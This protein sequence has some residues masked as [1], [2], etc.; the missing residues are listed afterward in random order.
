MNKFFDSITA[1]ELVEHLRQKGYKVEKEEKP[2]WTILSFKDPKIADCILKLNEVRGTYYSNEEY[3]DKSKSTLNDALYNSWRSV[4]T[5]H[6]FIHSVR[7]ESDGEVFTLGDIVYH[8]NDRPDNNGKIESLKIRGDQLYAFS[9]SKWKTIHID[10]L[11]RT[12]TTLFTT[13]DGVELT[14][15]DQKIYS[16]CPNDPNFVTLD[17]LTVARLTHSSNFGGTGYKAWKHFSTEEA[18]NQYIRHNKPVFSGTDI[19]N[20]IDK[21]RPK[22]G[23]FIDADLI[24]DELGH[25]LQVKFKNTL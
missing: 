15:K 9:D 5:G 23:R 13:E 4:K 25:E 11:K 14:K 22:D 2:E 12:P 10:Y 19:Q 8:S 18:R 17:D 6:W 20:I 16:V 1:E 21:L 24:E 7:R 3:K